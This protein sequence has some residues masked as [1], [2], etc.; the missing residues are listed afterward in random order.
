MP[1]SPQPFTT[2]NGQSLSTETNPITQ[3]PS[4]SITNGGAVNGTNGLDLLSS[5]CEDDNY[6]SALQI[7]DNG[8]TSQA[9]VTMSP[10][11]AIVP[12]VT[13]SS[14]SQIRR[15]V[16]ALFQEQSSRKSPASSYNSVNIEKKNKYWKGNY[17][18]KM[19][20]MLWLRENPIQEKAVV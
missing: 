15:T 17:N 5:V 2:P 6:S 18:S 11:Q 9:P 13:Q 16:V 4:S 19:S 8:L 10:T 14:P 7:Y 12:A 20:M 1:T 3:S